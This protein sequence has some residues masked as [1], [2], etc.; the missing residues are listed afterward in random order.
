M[1]NVWSARQA[2]DF[3]MLEADTPSANPSDVRKLNLPARRRAL[4]RNAQAKKPLSIE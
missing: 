3:M 4:R 1:G 2:F